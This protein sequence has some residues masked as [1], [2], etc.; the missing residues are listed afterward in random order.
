[1]VASS[2]GYLLTATRE[3]GFLRVKGSFL[4]DPGR[5]LPGSVFDFFRQQEGAL[6]C[7]AFLGTLTTARL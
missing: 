7:V 2:P 5:S 4:G 3:D 1:M 6:V